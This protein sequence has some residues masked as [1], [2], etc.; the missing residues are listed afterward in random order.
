MRLRRLLFRTGLALAGLGLLGAASIYVVLFH[1][2]TLAGKSEIV[3]VEGGEIEGLH[4]RGLS[5]YRG[6]PFAAPPTGAL[7]WR[8]PQPVLPWRGVRDAT[9]FADVCMQSGETVPGL[10]VEPISEDCLYLNVWTPAEARDEGLPV[11]IWLYGGGH[12]VGSGSARLYWGER[13]AREGVV[14]VTLNYRLGAFGMM[15]HPELSNEAPYGASGN[16]LLL[17][18]IAALAWVRR[19][20]AAFGGDPD[21]VTLFGQSAGATSIS[22]LIA[23]PR[24]DGLFTRAIAQSGGDLRG[25][26]ET[27]PLPE[28]EAIGV[29]FAQKLGVTSLAQLRTLP[30]ETILA[31]DVDGYFD[32]GTPQGPHKIVNDPWLLPQTVSDAYRDGSIRAMPLLVG[33]NSGDDPAVHQ[34]TGRRWAETHAGTGNPVYAYYFTRV[35]PY[36][37]F[38]FRGI[39][40]HGAELIYLFG[41]P[42]PLFFYAVEFPW[43]AAR[44]AELSDQMISYWTNFAKTGNPNGEG[45]PNWPE[46]GTA[47]EAL[48]L[49]DTSFIISYDDLEDRP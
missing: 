38:R 32:N 9:R 34:D 49:G 28:G 26:P 20:I 41:F 47:Q 24:A 3:R 43:N 42:P 35:P 10:G 21:N 29:A 45:L 18:Q 44:D 17:D 40:G 1:P 33:Y 27:I 5:L 46:Y 19:N 30:A 14:V 7:R 16:Y 48:E 2:L 22:R 11:M 8:A 31:N 6:I 12:H 13:L 15:A 39:A 25:Q 23:S 4:W 36:P 37:P